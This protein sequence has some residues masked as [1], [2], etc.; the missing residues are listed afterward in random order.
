METFSITPTPCP[1]C[2][3]S[4]S[5]LDKGDKPIKENDLSVC[6]SCGELLLIGPY[7]TFKKCDLTPEQLADK[8]G[9]LTYGTLLQVQGEIQTKAAAVKILKQLTL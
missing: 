6:I 7:M 4:I 8:L 2:G 3:K 9:L 5:A 1:Y